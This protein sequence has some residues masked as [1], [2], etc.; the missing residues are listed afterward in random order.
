MAVHYGLG[1][2]PAVA[3]AALRHRTPALAA[4]VPLLF[5][6][7]GHLYAAQAT[8]RSRLAYTHHVL[9]F[10]V[11]LCAPCGR[12]RCPDAHAPAHGA[13]SGVTAAR[14]SRL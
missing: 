11:I 6:L 13:R 10:V 2:A 8:G 4:S 1:T 3:Y 9:G 14:T 5:G 7:V 12:A